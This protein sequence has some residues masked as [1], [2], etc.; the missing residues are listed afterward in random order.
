MI[1]TTTLHSPG[2]SW[3][4]PDTLARLALWPKFSVA[5][6]EAPCIKSD[7]DFLNWFKQL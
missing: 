5:E 1:E 6:V 3:D 4:F 7:I 2:R